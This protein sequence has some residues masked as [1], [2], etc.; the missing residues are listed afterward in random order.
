MNRIKACIASIICTIAIFQ[1]FAQEG[2][3]AFS[4]LGL[5]TSTRANALGGTN[6]SVIENDI[7]LVFLNPAALGPEMNMNAN[8]NFL[9]YISDIKVGSAIF[10]KS[11]RE[12]NSFAVGVNYIDYGDFKEAIN[13]EVIGSFSGKDIAVNGVYSHMLTNRLRGGVTAKFITSNYEDYSSTAIGFDVG[14]SYYNEDREFSAGLVLKN[15]GS[16]ISSYDDKRVGLPW[17]VQLGISKKLNNA[18]IRLSLTA[19]YLTQWDF[20]RVNEANGIDTSDDGFLKTA[21]KHTILGVDI[22]PSENF[23]ISAGF[24]PKVHYDMA[25]EDGNKFGGFN[26]GAGIR[27]QK[28]SIGFSLAKFHPAATTYHFSLAVDISKF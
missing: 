13:G 16:Q 23:W 28:F 12:N 18:P 10:G 20:A 27:I 4:F 25:L 26:G 15:M 11:I 1:S 19:V 17:D 22:I 2:E 21:F 6:I 8:V 9:S 3:R 7:S 14:L 24:N 5:P